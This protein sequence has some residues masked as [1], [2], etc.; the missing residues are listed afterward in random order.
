MLVELLELLTLDTRWVP[1]ALALVGLLAI[2]GDVG[3]D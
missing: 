1:E 2:F 3:A